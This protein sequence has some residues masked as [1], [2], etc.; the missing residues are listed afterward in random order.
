MSHKPKVFKRCLNLCFTKWHFIDFKRGYTTPKNLTTKFL[1]HPN[2]KWSKCQNTQSI[3][4]PYLQN[5]KISKFYV[6]VNDT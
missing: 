4:T 5:I 1:K 3:R 6:Q 2:F